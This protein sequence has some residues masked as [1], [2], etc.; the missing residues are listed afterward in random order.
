MDMD[1]ESNTAAGRS[2]ESSTSEL[3]H[4]SL[5]QRPTRPCSPEFPPK[6][7]PDVP[8]WLTK[9]LKLLTLPNGEWTILFLK[10]MSWNTSTRWFS[11]DWLIGYLIN[12][13]IDWSICTGYSAHEAQEELGRMLEEAME[14]RERQAHEDAVASG[15]GITVKLGFFFV[16]RTQADRPFDWL[17]DMFVSFSCIVRLIDWLIN[18]SNGSITA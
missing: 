9:C 3:P 2:A 14:R 18:Y 15:S 13:L 8:P 12:W 16:K 11:V 17:I 4:A 10:P 7:S 5:P 1:V 6:M